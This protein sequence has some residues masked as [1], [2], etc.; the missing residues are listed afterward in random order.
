MP[1]E[2]SENTKSIAQILGWNKTSYFMMSSFALL[3][4]VI[5]Y[6]WWP[7][8]EE[9]IST[10]NPDLPFWIQ[11]DWLLF[12]IFLVM[13]LLIMA[14]IAITETAITASAI[15]TF[16]ILATHSVLNS[17]DSMRFA[18]ISYNYVDYRIKAGV[19]HSANGRG[20]PLRQWRTAGFGR[21]YRSF[22]SSMSRSTLSPIR[23][24][25]GHRTCNQ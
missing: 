8:L 9:Y 20:R 12:G 1:K 22:H 5:G 17:P 6:V 24:R 16:I 15:L 18:P 11:F 19:A 2:Y 14:K 4:F 10:Y 25:M 3:L 21:L 23:G 7:L 13:S